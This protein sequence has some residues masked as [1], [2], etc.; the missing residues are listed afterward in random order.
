MVARALAGAPLLTAEDHQ[1]ALD[2]FCATHP[3]MKGVAAI[4]AFHREFPEFAK[5]VAG[6][7]ATPN[8]PVRR[9]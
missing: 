7:T 5:C 2:A 1:Q 9:T 6:T 8:R 3:E 4:R